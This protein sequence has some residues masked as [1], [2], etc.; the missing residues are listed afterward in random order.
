ME[1][2]N[3]LST[4]TRH[5]SLGQRAGGLVALEYEGGQPWTAGKEDAQAVVTDSRLVMVPVDGQGL[6]L[7]VAGLTI[8]LK[9]TFRHV[10]KAGAV[11]GLEVGTEGRLHV[12]RQGRGEEADAGGRR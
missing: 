12:R 8:R 3:A 9:Y 10:R 1:R 11:V 6:N 7:V 4:G 2:R 5:N